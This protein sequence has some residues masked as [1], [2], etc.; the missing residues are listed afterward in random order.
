LRE[1]E[2]GLIS[3]STERKSSNQEIQVKIND[4]K[5]RLFGV[6]KNNVASFISLITNGVRAGTA[7][8]DDMDDSWDVLIFVPKE[9][10]TIENLLSMNILGS[11]GWVPIEAIIDIKEASK[12]SVIR[13]TDGKRT[14]DITSDIEEEINLFD[15]I[16]DIELIIEKEKEDF[17]GINTVIRGQVEDAGETSHFMMIAFLTSIFLMLSALLYQFNSYIKS[18]LV[19]VAVAFSTL[20]VFFIVSILQQ[21]FS[22][23][24]SG[25]A[26]LSLA[27]ISINHNI[28]LIDEFLYLKGKGY[29][30]KIAALFSATSRFKPIM[31]T[32]MT[33]SIGL[34]PMIFEVSI[35]FMDFE[36]LFGDPAMATWSQMA[37]NIAGGLFISAI[38]SLLL[39]PTMLS[40][41]DNR[42]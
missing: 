23:V 17:N 8:L 12:T 37:S 33:T 40:F 13:R 15:I 1:A 31:L 7:T 19:F 9:E 36:I 16:D 4:K 34:S 32:V 28:I 5:A 25:L 3:I 20:G 10:R 30:S 38:I 27:G 18:L 29:N 39:T 14:I 22:V 35:D 26:I 6:N 21:E 24:F 41:I 11:N 2:L 42:N